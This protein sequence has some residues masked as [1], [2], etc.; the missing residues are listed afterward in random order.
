[1]FV[2]ILVKQTLC[3]SNWRFSVAMALLTSPMP[4]AIV[5]TL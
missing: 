5:V 3:Y 4:V 2:N 1:M